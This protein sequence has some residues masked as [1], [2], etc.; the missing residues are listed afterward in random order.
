VVC[1]SGAAA[2]FGHFTR[3]VWPIFQPQLSA[4][5]VALA[6]HSSIGSQATSSNSKNSRQSQDS[7]T[8]MDWQNSVSWRMLFIGAG[9][10]YSTADI[11]TASSARE[12][13]IKNE[14]HPQ[15]PFYFKIAVA[16]GNIHKSL[17][18]RHH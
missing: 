12:H 14:R 7:H 11:M 13:G 4:P 18:L 8:S 9:N 17:N 16:R 2:H 1:Y 6:A 5:A 3:P 15:A 10:R